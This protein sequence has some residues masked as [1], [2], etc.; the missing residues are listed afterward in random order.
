LIYFTSVTKAIT[1]RQQLTAI[2]IAI[3]NSFTIAAAALGI[4]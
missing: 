4:G 1:W 2:G 3:I